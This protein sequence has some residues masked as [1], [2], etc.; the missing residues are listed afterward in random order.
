MAS[1]RQSNPRIKS[2]RYAAG[3]V[4]IT[5][6]G[7]AEAPACG[8]RSLKSVGVNFVDVGAGHLARP[9]QQGDSNRA[10]R[11]NGVG[12]GLAVVPREANGF[13]RVVPV[14]RFA[15]PRGSALAERRGGGPQ[16][17]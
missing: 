12:A 5:G 13:R 9:D 1:K 2:D 15:R 4:G 7:S 16:D 3:A 11:G 14:G 17:D 6:I 8:F 10:D